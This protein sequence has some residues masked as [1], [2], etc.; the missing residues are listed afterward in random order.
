MTGGKVSHYRI[1][2]CLGEG[3][4][5]VVYKGV[6][7]R[8]DRPVALKFLSRQLANDPM[9][10]E[11]FRQELAEAPTVPRPP[12]RWV[13]LYNMSTTPR[14]RGDGVM[15]MH[16]AGSIEAGFGY[17]QAPV[18]YAGSN[19]GAGGR[20]WGPWYWFSDD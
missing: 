5:G 10:M 2:E 17:S 1:E 20:L 18:E 14:I 19:L 4:M 15:Q 13:G 3:G 9:A 12:T 16:L 7:T 11:R 6:D 8:L